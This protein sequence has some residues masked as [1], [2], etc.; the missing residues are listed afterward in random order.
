MK[1]FQKKTKGMILEERL[2]FWGQIEVVKIPG[3]SE[4]KEHPVDSIELNKF[5]MDLVSRH[6]RIF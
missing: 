5:D 2:C 3:P 4:K 6:S 1:N